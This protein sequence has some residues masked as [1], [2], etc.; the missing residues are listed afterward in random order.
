MMGSPVLVPF[1]GRWLVGHVT[2]FGLQTSIENFASICEAVAHVETV[3]ER[4]PSI[5]HRGTRLAPRDWRLLL[6]VAAGAES[7]GQAAR[8]VGA[9]YPAS[10]RS[11][12]VLGEAG[13]VD[14]QGE[15]LAATAEG[16][17]LARSIRET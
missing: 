4:P 17:A 13:L 5:E 2:P 1:A 8:A 16:V 7:N 9:S 12:S 10:R 11:L 3:E 14:A 6:A 15:R